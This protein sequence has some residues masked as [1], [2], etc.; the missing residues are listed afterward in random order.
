MPCHVNERLSLT[1]S[2]MLDGTRQCSFLSKSTL[3][4]PC[5]TLTQLPKLLASKVADPSVSCR[6]DDLVCLQTVWASR[7]AVQAQR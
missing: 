4:M 7:L 1:S 3:S 6:R 2:V 5:A